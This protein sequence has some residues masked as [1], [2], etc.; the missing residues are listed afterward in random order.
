MYENEPMA[1]TAKQ[2]EHFEIATKM[3]SEIVER[4]NPEQQNEVL[5]TIRDFVTTRRKEKIE[6]AAKELE[7][8]KYSLENMGA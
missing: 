4:Y 3:A 1:M 2:P 8:L 7:A 6:M 5:R